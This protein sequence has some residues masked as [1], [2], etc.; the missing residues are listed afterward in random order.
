R[1]LEGAARAWVSG[2]VAGL[3]PLLALGR[4]AVGEAVRVDLALEPFLE[5]VVADG[6]GGVEAVG[7]V[8]VGDALDQGVTAVGAG[9]GGGVVG[10][11]AGGAVGLEVQA[12]P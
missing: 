6:G 1:P 8:L 2:A 11:Q 9:L 3:E 4:G 10:P 5:G 12:A 7:D